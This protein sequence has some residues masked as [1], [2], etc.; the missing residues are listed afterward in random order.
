MVDDPEYRQITHLRNEAL[1]AA[2]LQP[3]V[4]RD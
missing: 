2:D 4:T 3:T 1:D